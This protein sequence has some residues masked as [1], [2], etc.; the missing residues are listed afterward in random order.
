[1]LPPGS[2]TLIPAQRYELIIKHL[3][4]HKIASNASLANLL[5]VSESTI[6]RDLEELETQGVLE[7]TRGGAI[8]SQRIRMEEEYLQRAQSHIQEKKQI[9]KKAASLVEAG[10]LVF[11]NSGTTT[12]EV[13]RQIKGIPN[14]T[15]I[16]NNTS[17]ISEARE[18]DFELILLG[19]TFLPLS[20]AVVGLFTSDNVNQIYATKAFIGV[21]GISLKYG[22]TVST[23]QEA[24]II[25]LMIE[26]TQGPV[27]IVSDHSKWG[28]VSNHLIARIEQIHKVV[29]DPGLD[30]TA[31]VSLAARSVDVI[32]ADPAS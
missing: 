22:C 17:A 12:A 18:I 8:L 29:I 27:T 2:D 11:I 26:H 30:L 19:G 1:L 32:L 23:H 16:T 21:E 4:S 14:V 13:I 6:R 15:V 10:D 9:G 31:R 25:R 24:E 20:N 5:N 3:T 28:A 7:R